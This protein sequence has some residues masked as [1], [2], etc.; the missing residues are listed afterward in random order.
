[1]GSQLA[2][3]I[4]T[5]ST[6]GSSTSSPDS[7]LVPPGGFGAGPRAA[8]DMFWFNV[9]SAYVGCNNS[10]ASVDCDFA[11]YGYRYDNVTQ[12]SRE[13]VTVHFPVPGCQD[14]EGCSLARIDFGDW[15]EGISAIA[16]TASVNGTGVNWFMD[17]VAMSWWNNTCAAGLYRIQHEH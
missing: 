7:G 17:S 15:F 2:E 14:F 13:F 3:F 6:D 5:D 12:D 16:F 1:M 4:P 8:S 10:Q 9:D 11:V